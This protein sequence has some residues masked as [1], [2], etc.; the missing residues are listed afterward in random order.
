MLQFANDTTVISD[1]IDSLYT[2]LQLSMLSEISIP[3]PNKKKTK[4]MWIGSSKENKGKILSFQYVKEPAQIIGTYLS[5][6]KMKIR[7]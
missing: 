2:S 7:P 3:K 1:N 6:N 4:A 5:Y